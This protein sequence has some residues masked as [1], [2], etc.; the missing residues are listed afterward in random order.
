[1]KLN[2][3]EDS[4]NPDFDP[5]SLL[6]QL[7]DVYEVILNKLAQAGAEWI[8]LDEPIFSKNLTEPQQNVFARTYARLSQNKG[9][10][11]LMVTNYFGGIQENLSTYLNLPVE[12]LHFDF[13]RGKEDLTSVLENFTKDKI[14]SAGI[15][16][17]RNIWK[18][19]YQASLKILE[20]VSS[21]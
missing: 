19:D 21:V 13:V 14:L 10:A 15:V 18:N 2:L 16:E 1:M 12:A 17:G 20:N 5:F 7:I 11:K 4:K 3:D 8:Q 6:D 9:T